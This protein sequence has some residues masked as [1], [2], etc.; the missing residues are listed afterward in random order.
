MPY[1]VMS[2]ETN[3]TDNDDE[4]LCNLLT[5]AYEGKT[6][7]RSLSLDEF[8]YQRPRDEEFQDRIKNRNKDQVINKELNDWKKDGRSATIVRVNQ[9][10]LW[11][12][13]ESKRFICRCCHG[14]LLLTPQSN[15]HFMLHFEARFYRR[16]ISPTC[17]SRS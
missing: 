3:N 11:V 16:S 12:V 15:S 8:H 14:G 13:N 2:E 6:V 7:H 1:L 10:W 17:L 5:K 9:L 4:A